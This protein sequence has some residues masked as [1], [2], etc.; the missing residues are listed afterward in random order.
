[1]LAE[2]PDNLFFP[3]NGSCAS[4]ILFSM[5]STIPWPEF[6]G[7]GQAQQT[8]IAAQCRSR[9]HC[10]T[11]EIQTD[12]RP[13]FLVLRGCIQSNQKRNPVAVGALVIDWTKMPQPRRES[14]APIVR[15]WSGLINM[16][17]VAFKL[18]REIQ[19]RVRQAGS[20]PRLSAMTQEIAARLDVP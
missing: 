15:L 7:L 16:V 8:A 9:T 12:P 13:G 17:A 6:R 10:P 20:L 1:V 18:A 4:S 2:H 19:G 14:V 11:L 5:D 3:N